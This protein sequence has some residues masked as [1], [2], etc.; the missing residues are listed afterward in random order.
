MNSDYKFVNNKLQEEI[1]YMVARHYF[2]KNAV[3][4]RN[5]MF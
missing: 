1:V 4:I 5:L 2:M 3:Y